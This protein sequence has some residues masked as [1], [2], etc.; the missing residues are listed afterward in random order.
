MPKSRRTVRCRT[1]DIFM[2]ICE[3]QVICSNSCKFERLSNASQKV[4]ALLS[5]KIHAYTGDDRMQHSHASTVVSHR[6]AA[7]HAAELWVVHS[8][9][10][11][12]ATV[13][14]THSAGPMLGRCEPEVTQ[15]VHLTPFRACGRGRL[16]TKVAPYL[17]QYAYG[18]ALPLWSARSIFAG[19]DAAAECWTIL[20]PSS[21]QGNKSPQS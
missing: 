21:I 5:I 20:L 6:E 15:L 7:R 1:S 3:F 13:P 9:T 17:Q 19:A 14:G 16:K 8:L 2:P 4:E 12:I 11:L 10:R 18:S